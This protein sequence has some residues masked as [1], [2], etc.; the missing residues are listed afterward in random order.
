MRRSGFWRRPAAF[1][2]D[3]IFVAL[4]FLALGFG[5]RYLARHQQIEFTDNQYYVAGYV[6]LLIYFSWEF[7]TAASLGKFITG[8]EIA[9]ADG[10][11]A[12]T[13]VLLNR[14]TAKWSF[15]IVGLVAVLL[16]QALLSWLAGLLELVVFIGCFAVLGESKLAWHDRW[17]RTAVFRARDLRPAP[18]FEPVIAPANEADDPM[19]PRQ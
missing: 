16:Q 4:I 19:K 5:R 15:L 11:E 2:L 18:G 13:A 14:W 1:L 10:S 8:L 9:G 7:G 3:S 17:A 6:V 12:S